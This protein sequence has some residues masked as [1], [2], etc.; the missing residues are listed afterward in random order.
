MH[1]ANRQKARR[2]QFDGLAYLMLNY[3][4]IRKIEQ[5]R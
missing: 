2:A 4:E 3:V 5:E 1:C